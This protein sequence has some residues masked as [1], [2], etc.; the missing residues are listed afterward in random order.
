MQFS[1]FITILIKPIHGTF[2]YVQEKYGLILY[3]YFINFLDSHHKKVV[4]KV[5]EK[6]ISLLSIRYFHILCSE[7]IYVLSF[8]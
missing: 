6:F 5:K 8:H 4:E 7:I 3:L 1:N 2:N